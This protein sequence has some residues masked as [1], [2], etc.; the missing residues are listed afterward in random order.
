MEEQQQ[1]PNLAIPLVIGLAAFVLML[2]FQ[3]AQV[4]SQRSAL[5]TAREGQNGPLDES[6][7]VRKQLDTLSQSTASLAGKGNV[8]AQ[9]VVA[10]LARQGVQIHPPK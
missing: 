1:Q 10:N 8:N 4:I 3:T 2:G 7:K 5:A 6:N 9:A